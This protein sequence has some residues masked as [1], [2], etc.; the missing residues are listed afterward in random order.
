MV[1]W[2]V[3][4]GVGPSPTRKSGL[5][6]SPTRRSQ[7]TRAC[8]N[9]TSYRLELKAYYVVLDMRSYIYVNDS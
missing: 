1:E 4:S 5:K 2:G 6:A 8:T 9:T 7:G 3:R